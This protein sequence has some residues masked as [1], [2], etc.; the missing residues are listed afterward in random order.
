M[1]CSRKAPSGHRSHGAAAVAAAAHIRR[2][3]SVDNRPCRMLPGAAEARS[4]RARRTC[5]NR[6]T[7]HCRSSSARV[8]AGQTVVVCKRRTSVVAGECCGGAMGCARRP[9][10]VVAEIERDGL[11][12]QR[13]SRL[14]LCRPL[15]PTRPRHP[16]S[17]SA[18]Q[19]SLAILRRRLLSMNL[20]M[21]CLQ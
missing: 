1:G 11:Q 9:R 6:R 7:A 5:S 4:G 8:Q 17:R 13:P 14:V 15:A 16:A 3:D 10:C 21:G 19:S 2:H 20:K 18:R 12:S